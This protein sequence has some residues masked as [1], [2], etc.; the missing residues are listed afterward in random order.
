MN[1]ISSLLQDHLTF[2]TYLPLNNSSR[3]SEVDV[4]QEPVTEGLRQG[5]HAA[6][7]VQIP[8]EP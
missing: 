4:G 8:R 2:T 6:Y 7:P 5:C 3:P 1:F